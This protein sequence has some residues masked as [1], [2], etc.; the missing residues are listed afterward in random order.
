LPTTPAWMAALPLTVLRAQLTPAVPWRH[1][2]PVL[3]LRGALGD[4]MLHLL[5]THSTPLCTSC[6]RRSS[7]MM[8]TWYDP[9]R[10][11]ASR[12]RPFWIRA[13]SGPEGAIT[14]CH[15]IQLVWTFLGPLPRPTLP[16]EALS[17]AAAVG[18]GE[19]RIPHSVH[20]QWHDGER[21]TERG[22]PQPVPLSS[23]AGCPPEGP[24]LLQTVS[25]LRLRRDKQPIRH[26]SLS[27]VLQALILRVRELQRQLALPSAHTWP[28]PAPGH[29][30]Q[31]CRWQTG[32]RYSS[33]QQRPVD[34]SGAH[35]AWLLRPDEHTPFRD[36]LAAA[37]W[38]QLGAATTAGLG[39]LAL[40]TPVEGRSAIRSPS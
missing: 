26:P 9:E 34:L 4:A 16:A 37:P 22:S 38:L 2:E 11:G 36:L 8:P 29:P 24:L 32:S 28:A 20:L 6:L 33:R 17:R 10:S 1:D 5:C 27:D 23:L 35:A 31:S 39:A 40:T 25:R 7:C 14:P 3:A 15:P 12:A 21:W 18:L 30:A 19:E 13:T